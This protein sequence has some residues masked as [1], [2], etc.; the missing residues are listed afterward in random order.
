MCLFSLPA[1]KSLWM[2]TF[3]FWRID[4]LM[5]E[6]SDCRACGFVI[7]LTFAMFDAILFGDILKLTCLFYSCSA[8]VNAASLSGEAAPTMRLS[9][10]RL[11]TF[12]GTASC[13]WGK[14][15]AREVCD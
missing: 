7:F 8:L 10:P 4:S 1:M 15:G 3:I 14:S 2:L 11:P 5:D 13:C 9:E 12:F 6:A